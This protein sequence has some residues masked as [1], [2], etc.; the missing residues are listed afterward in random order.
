MRADERRWATR[1][2]SPILGSIVAMAWGLLAPATATAQGPGTEDGHWTY[3]GGD[4]WHTR[5]TPVDQLTPENF[6]ELEV[7][8]EWSATSFGPSTARATPSLVD[9]KLIT[10]AGNRRH[11]V[12]LDPVS[13]DLLWSFREPNTH[14]WEYSM[15]QGYGKGIAYTEIDGRGVVF[16]TSPAFFLHALDA[17]TGKPLENWGRPVPVAG[18][19]AKFLWL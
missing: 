18:F 9:G 8:W 3:L 4:A 14:R 6:D 10:V 11:V 13:G 17:E 19:E 1:A 2:V 5:Y 12:A 16:I 15:R 7:A